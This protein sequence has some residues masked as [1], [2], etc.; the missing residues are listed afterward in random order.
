MLEKL[1]VPRMAGTTIAYV[2]MFAVLAVVCLLMFSPVFGVA[3]SSSTHREHPY[4]KTS[5]PGATT[6]TRSIPTS[7][8]TPMSS[9]I[10]DALNALGTWAYRTP[11]AQPAWWPWARAWSIRLVAIG[12]SLVVAF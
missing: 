6:R 4:V 11:A 2:L 5:P 9:G 12:F 1:G 7:L 10:K 8:R 3:T